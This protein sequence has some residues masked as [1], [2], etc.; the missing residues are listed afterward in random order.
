M[1]TLNLD[2]VKL[3]CL[4]N[5]IDKPEFVPQCDNC[6]NNCRG[7]GNYVGIVFSSDEKCRH[8]FLGTPMGAMLPFIWWH[9]HGC[10]KWRHE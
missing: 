9:H 6:R 4:L 8:F 1:K 3:Y 5:N 7:A 10:A 2:K